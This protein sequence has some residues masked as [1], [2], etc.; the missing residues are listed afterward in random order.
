MMQEMNPRVFP[1][2]SFQE[3]VDVVDEKLFKTSS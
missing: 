3:R 1:L 2:D